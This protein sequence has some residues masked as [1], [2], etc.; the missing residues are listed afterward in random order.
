[1]CGTRRS[2]AGGGERRTVRL[3]HRGRITFV[4]RAVDRERGLVATGRIDRAVVDRQRFL[5]RRPDAA[6]R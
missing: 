3:R 4:V 1:M 2:V 5:A 6:D